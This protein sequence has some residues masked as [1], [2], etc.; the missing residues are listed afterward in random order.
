M[1]ENLERCISCGDP[2]GKAGAGEDSLYCSKC[3]NG[4]YCSEH[5]DHQNELGPCCNPEYL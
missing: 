3:E 4:P 2:T 5:Y 1:P